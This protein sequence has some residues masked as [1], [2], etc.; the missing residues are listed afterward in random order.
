MMGQCLRVKDGVKDGVKQG[1]RV[2]LRHLIE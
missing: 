2:I 1:V